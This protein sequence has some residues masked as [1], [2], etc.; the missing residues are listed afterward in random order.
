MHHTGGLTMHGG[1]EKK[2]PFTWIEIQNLEAYSAYCMVQ[3]KSMLKTLTSLPTFGGGTCYSDIISFALRDANMP[4]KRAGLYGALAGMAIQ[5]FIEI[6]DG[7]APRWGFSVLDVTFGT[8]G[9]FYAYAQNYV[10]VLA[11]T[12]IKISYYRYHDYYFKVPQEGK[13][14]WDEDY[15]NMNFWA[16]YNPYRVIRHG[17]HVHPNWPK[18]LGISVGAG[19]D[20]TLDG[21]YTGTNS[22][23]NK[24]KGNHQLYIAPDIDFTGLFPKSKF[25]H[26]LARVFNRV[27]FPMPTFRVAPDIHFFPLYF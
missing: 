16:T 2:H 27:K 26:N 3:M 9:S 11:A 8:L 4:A 18:W 22:G 23:S 15:M 12:D 5:G 25:F 6:K 14:T 24:G 19:V 7:Y 13:P 17:Q 1:M 20:E 10:P 21:Y